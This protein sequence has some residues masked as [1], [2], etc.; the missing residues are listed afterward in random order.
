M[1]VI[2]GT[3]ALV[4]VR[5]SGA[6]GDGPAA[7]VLV[8]GIGI[9]ASFFVIWQEAMTRVHRELL[10]RPEWG[11]LRR[12]GLFFVALIAVPIAIGLTYLGVLAVLM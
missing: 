4:I 2:A 1:I 6:A 8:A 11:D 7:V 3:V 5:R 12:L 10:A 9:L